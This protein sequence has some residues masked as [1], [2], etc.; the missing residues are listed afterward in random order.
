MRNSWHEDIDT[1]TRALLHEGLNE[2]ISG[3]RGYG[4]FWGMGG[5]TKNLIDT[6]L[7]S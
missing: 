2:G 3:I 4:A 5:V 7:I 1:M 6:L